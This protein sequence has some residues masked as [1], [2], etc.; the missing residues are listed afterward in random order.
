MT[1][2]QIEDPFE[3][4]FF[5]LV[6]LLYL[7]PF[8]DGNKRTA[9]LTAN[10][11]FVVNNLVPL[12]FVDVP[13]DTFQRAYLALYELRRVEPL[14][15]LFTWAY[16]RSVARLGQVR[17]SLGEPDLFRLEHRQ[18][19]RAA[20]KQIV[21]QKVRPAKRRAWLER[22]SEEHL[23]K[24]ARIRFVAMAEQELAALNEVTSVRYGLRP[25]ELAAWGK[26]SAG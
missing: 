13:A 11:P 14:R 24:K 19:L 22:F 2:Q 6:Q 18:T 15:D 8:L 7:Q 10:L 1:A 21:Q 5:L 26:G 12:S 4:S 3:C 16:E 17:A 9:R 25:S 23:P 20:V